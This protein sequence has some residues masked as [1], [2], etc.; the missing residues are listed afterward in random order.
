MSHHGMSALNLI[1][2]AGAACADGDKM[3]RRVAQKSAREA[4][5]PA[6]A[7]YTVEQRWSDEFAKL[8]DGWHDTT[9]GEQPLARMSAFLQREVV[10]RLTDGGG[11]N[12]RARVDRERWEQLFGWAGMPYAE[13]SALAPSLLHPILCCLFA[14]AEALRW[15]HFGRILPAA[16]SAPAVTALA[17]L[18]G[19]MNEGF[20]V[21]SGHIPLGFVFL[22]QFIDHDITLDATTALADDAFTV[23]DILNLRTPAL[24]LD[25][26]YRDGPEGSPYLY[27]QQR[28]TAS[29]GVGYLLVDQGCHDLP[30]NQQGR[31]LIGDPRN[32][33]NL[34]ISQ[35]HLQF[36]LFHNAVLRLI[37]TGGVDAIFG[38]TSEEIGHDFDFARRLVRWHYQWLMVNEFLPMLVDATALQAAHAITGVPQGIG[39]AVP[40]LPPGYETAQN[41]LRRVDRVDCCGRRRKGPLISVEFSG[42]AFRFA[43]SQVPSRLDINANRLDVPIF[44]PRPPAPGAFTPALDAVDWRRFFVLDGSSPQRARPI[45]TSIAAQLY[46]LPFISDGTPSLPLRNLIRSTQTYRVPTG[47]AA[48]TALGITGGGMSSSARAKAANAGLADN[49]P[50]WFYCLG[51]AENFSGRLGSLGGLVVAW[52]LLRMLE[53][54][55]RSYVNAPGGAWK[56][57]LNASTPGQFGVADLIRIA[58]AERQDACPT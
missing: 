5:A 12:A 40:P 20:G 52:T 27:D 37:E 42:A 50:L 10:P 16:T 55:E 46:T 17:Q 58:Q 51:E 43:H 48:A 25:S 47:E 49:T 3:I 18:A 26:V 41:R 44:T 4:A 38:R 14:K 15:N 30:R 7:G 21:P 53:C 56:P 8:L 54:D 1:T 11:T 28:R 29:N 32:D 6:M 45:D 57:V 34:F 35:L 31:A 33:E 23:E 2:L 39:G 19:T 9:Q 24:D 36:L 22:A 13:I